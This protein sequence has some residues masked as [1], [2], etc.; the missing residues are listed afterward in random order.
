MKNKAERIADSVV[1]EIRAAGKANRAEAAKIKAAGMKI[2]K[3][4][5]PPPPKPRPPYLP[6]DL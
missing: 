6:G 5:K 1:R 4:P 2:P 3:T